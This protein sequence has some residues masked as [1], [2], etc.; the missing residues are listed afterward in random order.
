[1]CISE[2][3]FHSFDYTCA[4]SIFVL[5]EIV[6]VFLRA[7]NAHPRKIHPPTAIFR[8]VLHRE[9]AAQAKELEGSMTLRT[10]GS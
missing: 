7:V 2:G 4:F 8:L 10:A 3:A 9:F 5:V 1:M 6:R